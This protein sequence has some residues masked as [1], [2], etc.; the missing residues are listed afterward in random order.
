[1]GLGVYPEVSIFEARRLATE[2]RKIIAGGADPIDARQASRA[3][4]SITFEQASRQMHDQKKSGW[5]QRHSQTWITSLEMH[6][7]PIIGSVLVEL[8]R[9]KDFRNV[10]EP[11]WLTLPETANRV[12]QRCNAVMNC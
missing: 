10:L 2:A 6:A 8:L 1:M 7:F 11:I 3:T 9:A 5:G 4:P 12:K